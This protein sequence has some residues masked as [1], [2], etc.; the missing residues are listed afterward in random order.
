MLFEVGGGV[1]LRGVQPGEPGEKRGLV[2]HGG[3]F[4]KIIRVI[5]LEEEGS[6]RRKD[7]MDAREIVRMDEPM[8]GVAFLGPG[9]WKEEV[10]PGG[11]T[12]GQ[13]PGKRVGAFKVDDPDIGQAFADGA[14]VLNTIDN[15]FRDFDKNKQVVA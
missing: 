11:T 4:L 15:I 10:N 8:E 5:G 7:A 13:E 2:H 1:K 3:R 9:I 12:G 14:A 6:P